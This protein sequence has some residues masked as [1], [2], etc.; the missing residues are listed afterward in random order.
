MPI[1]NIFDVYNNTFDL[2]S[3]IVN[4]IVSDL[5]ALLATNIPLN[6]FKFDYSLLTW[7]PPETNILQAN[8]V[9]DRVLCI[10]RDAGIRIIV[11]NIPVSPGPYP[12]D[13]TPGFTPWYNNLGQHNTLEINIHVR[14]SQEFMK[15]WV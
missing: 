8:R 3:V 10:M 5:Q 14:S 12:C 13:F 15:T 4:N 11:K 9:V 6:I 2:D 1:Q 7:L